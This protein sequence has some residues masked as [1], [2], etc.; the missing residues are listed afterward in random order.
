MKRRALLVSLLLLQVQ[1]G[2]A[3][4]LIDSTTRNGSFESGSISPWASG[5][6]VE[7]PTFASAGSWYG[8][9]QNANSPTARS[10]A[11][12][13]FAIG[14]ENAGSTFKTSFDARTSASGAFDNVDAYLFGSQADGTTVSSEVVHILNLPSTSWINYQ[15]DLHLPPTW[16]GTGQLSLQLLF[17]TSRAVPGVT[18]VGYLDNVVL[19]QVPE[20]SATMMLC[21]AVGICGWKC[22]DYG[23]A[24]RKRMRRES[25]VRV[26][27]P[28]LAN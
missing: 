10:L 27:Q 9:F 11:F 20:P 19:E 2:S 26:S 16:D 18:Y 15:T 17:H 12:Q 6:A 24:R 4:I 7:D 8:V 5:I 21:L 22:W 28:S 1:H 3:A 14:P 25:S 23:F 13:G